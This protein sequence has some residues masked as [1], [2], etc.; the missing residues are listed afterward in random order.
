MSAFDPK[1]TLSLFTRLSPNGQQKSLPKA[2]IVACAVVQPA[3]T[4]AIQR[5][6]FNLETG[7]ASWGQATGPQVQNRYQ[8]PD[9][10]PDGYP[11]RDPAIG[12]NAAMSFHDI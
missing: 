8:D 4:R 9:S 10:Y 5:P 7:S 12:T 2:S 11:D 6:D 1:R 3:Q